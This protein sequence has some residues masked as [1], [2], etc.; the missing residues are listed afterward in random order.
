MPRDGVPVDCAIQVTLSTPI[1]SRST[2]VMTSLSNDST[3]LPNSSVKTD[4][5]SSSSRAGTSSIGLSADAVAT[6]DASEIT[7]T[8]PPV[9]LHL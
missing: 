7:E 8:V 3:P 2:L 9:R 6:T 4:I 1:P 5:R